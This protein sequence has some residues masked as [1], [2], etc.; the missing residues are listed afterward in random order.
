MHAGHVAQGGLSRDG[1]LH[2]EAPATDLQHG[3]GVHLTRPQSHHWGR[4]LRGCALGLISCT[5][6]A[7]SATTPAT[8]STPTADAVTPVVCTVARPDP[9]A[10]P[11]LHV[12]SICLTRTIAPISHMAPACSAS[13]CWSYRCCINKNGYSFSF[14]RSASRC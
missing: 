14:C 12:T 9:T 13:C 8:P 4:A 11:S 1:H 2:R 10:V 3:A 7:P 5:P 6:A